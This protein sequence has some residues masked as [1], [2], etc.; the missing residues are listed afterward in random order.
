MP[1][2]IE[3]FFYDIMSQIQA[4]LPNSDDTVKKIKTTTARYWT[5]FHSPYMGNVGELDAH[6]RENIRHA[7]YNL[8]IN[9]FAENSPANDNIELNDVNTIIDN[10]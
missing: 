3:S 2:S 1:T 6:R 9:S 7:I 4:M 5:I 10:A 8:I